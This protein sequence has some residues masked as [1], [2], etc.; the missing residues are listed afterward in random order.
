MARI[1][2]EGRADQ[3]LDAA[4]LHFGKYGYAKTT[5]GDIA[6]SAGVATGTVYLYYKSKDEVLR[7]C[8]LR[9]HTRHREFAEK[10]IASGKAPEAKMKEYI[11]NRYQNWKRETQGAASGSDLGQAMSSIAP[12]INEKEVALWTDTL[13]SILKDGQKARVYK[14]KSLTKELRIFLNCLVG[15]FPLPGTAHPFAPSEKDLNEMLLWFH[16]KWS[17]E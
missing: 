6:K 1:R 4:L 11:L 17:L 13:Q 2:A 16:Q 5:I 7:A 10:V 9:F 12:D 8:A 15:Y 3:I 14:F